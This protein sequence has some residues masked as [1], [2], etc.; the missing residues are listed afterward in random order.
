M[1]SFIDPQSCGAC[2]LCVDICPAHIPRRI[3]DNSGAEIVELNPERISFCIHCGHCMA[4]C[5]QKA[6]HIEG[7]YYDEEIFDLPASDGR[8]PEAFQALLASRRS[9]RA[10]KDKPVPREVLEQI[11]DAISQA[12]MGYP[13]HKIEITIIQDREIL[14]EA[15]PL[16]MDVYENLGDSVRNP[17]MRFMIRR[18]AGR[19]AFVALTEHVL[20][21]MAYR[22]PDMKAGGPDTITRGAPV[23]L[24]FHANR[25][26]GSH[27]EDAYIAVTYGL[28]AAHALG[29]GATVLSLVP[30]AVERTPA[31]RGL[32]HIKPD[33]HVVTSMI[34]GYPR[35]RFR[36][37][38]RR[39][40]AGVTWL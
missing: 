22:L 18:R 36:R 4:I 34:V 29:L 26:A 27:T 12:P 21:S 16:M 35:V 20:P 31:L 32:F 25:E 5:P 15:L 24:L 38:I 11:V 6:M 33:Q 19:E 37:G 40:L 28:L 39:E 10:F 9:V 14:D 30:S 13:P 17:F 8:H 2:G 7:L 1:T 23:L 3:R